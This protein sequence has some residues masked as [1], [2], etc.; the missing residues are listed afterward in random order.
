MFGFICSQHTP[1]PH[2]STHTFAHSVLVRNTARPLTHVMKPGL[3]SALTV[4]FPE[5]SSKFV[6]SHSG[7]TVPFLGRLHFKAAGA[8]RAP[9]TPSQLNMCLAFPP[10]G[11]VLL[12]ALLLSGR[13]HQFNNCCLFMNMDNGRQPGRNICGIIDLTETKTTIKKASLRFWGIQIYLEICHGL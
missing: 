4:W 13:H 8:D 10:Q 11:K 7:L 5:S 6:D 2:T 12:W 3:S 1:S 9:L